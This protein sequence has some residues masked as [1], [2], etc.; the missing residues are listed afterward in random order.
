MTNRIEQNISR[1]RIARDLDELR[2][3]AIE[4]GA[5]DAKV[6]GADQVIIDER[7][8][9]KCLY[10]KCA[11][12][13]T[14]AHCPPHAP[15]LDWARQVVSRFQ[16]GIFFTI[17]VPSLDFA[18]SAS[19]KEKLYTPH[20]QTLN[21]IAGE[22]EAAAF[23][24]GHYFALGFSAG[25]CKSIFCRGV[26]CQALTPGKGCRARMRARGSMEGF[27]MDAFGMATRAGWDIYPCGYRT[28]P[29]DIPYGR[30]VGLVLVN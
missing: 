24:M 11:A 17:E 27:G 16:N 15:S 12:Y 20:M 13:G 25:P 7:V 28:K 18:G 30:A 3:K 26:D 9:M 8:R 4:F 21:S 22:V 10:P 29:E 19:T 23:H 5:A 2:A 6:I 1:E 14:N